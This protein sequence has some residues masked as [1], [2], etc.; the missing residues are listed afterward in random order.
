MTARRRAN[1]ARAFC[2]LIGIACLG[3]AVAAVVA[4]ASGGYR[5]ERYAGWFDPIRAGALLFFGA[6][7]AGFAL[8]AAATL[9]LARSRPSV[10]RLSG[11]ALTA[12]LTV[13][14]LTGLALFA[15][16]PPSLAPV[17]LPDL[18]RVMVLLG[19]GLVAAGMVPVVLDGV[20]GALKRRDPNL[21]IA[22]I[23]LVLIVV[24]RLAS[25]E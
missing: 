12:G 8:A 6:G 13:M 18:F 22:L 16:A 3:L 4:I 5:P 15:S 2:A 7:A 11:L 25:Q 10:F 20:A 23:A 24:I 14:A 19:L 9:R 21:L 1:E 17:V